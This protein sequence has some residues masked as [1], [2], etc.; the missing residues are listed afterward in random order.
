MLMEKK[1]F[2]ERFSYELH[3]DNQGAAKRRWDAIKKYA[4]DSEDI[5]LLLGMD[6][7]LMHNALAEIK[8]HYDAGM[9]MTYGNWQDQFG[10]RLSDDFL[11]FDEQTHESRDYRKVYYRSTAPNTFKR[12]L[13]DQLTPAD[14]QVNGEWIRA[15]T[16]SNLMLSC[17]EMCGKEKIGVIKKPIYIY[18]KRG[19]Y[20]TKNVRGA[21]YQKSIY[22]NVI[23][24]PKKELYEC[25]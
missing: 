10:Q 9:W 5:I 19:R 15:T 25:R 17:L 24:R 1:C 11:D 22:Q 14:F 6:D 12:F 13:F 8:E 21:T 7:Y 23:N 4:T 20:S 18:N 3:N 2:D 16:E